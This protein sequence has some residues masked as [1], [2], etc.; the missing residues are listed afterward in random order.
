MKGTALAMDVF[1]RGGDFD[2]NNDPVVRIE[3][4][5]LRKAIEHYYLTSG[6]QDTLRIDVP[7][8]QYRPVFSKME[9][10]TPAPIQ[11]TFLAMPSI[12]IRSF[13][14]EAS[15]PSLVYRRGLPEEMALE[16]SRFDNIRVFS[17]W[18]TS[19]EGEDRPGQ[20]APLSQCDYILN[21]SVRDSGGQMRIT[22][23]LSR[24]QDNLLVWSER[25]DL[26]R[27]SMNVF[28]V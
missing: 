17:G 10:K 20:A 15:Q 26:N 24:T 22:V 21:G 6:V 8:G 11:P 3:G 23:Q 16:L 25:F 5:K 7:K 27:D 2:S 1:G 9:L 12:A 28:E 4:V 13:D 19:D 14:G 18:G